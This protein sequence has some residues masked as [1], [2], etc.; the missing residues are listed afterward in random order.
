MKLFSK[1]SGIVISTMVFAVV[2]LDTLAQNVGIGTN[3][4][5][6]KLHVV[7]T[8][9]VSSLAGVGNRSVL[10]DPNGTLIIGTTANS[11]DWTILGNSGTNPATNFLG[12]LDNVDMTIRRNNIERVRVETNALNFQGALEPNNLPGQVGEV[13]QSNGPGVAPTWEMQNLNPTQIVSWGKFYINNLTINNNTNYI[14]TIG[15]ANCTP[16]STLTHTWVGPLPGG[17]AYGLLVT[18]VEAQNGQW[19]FHIRNTTGWNF[20][21]MSLSFV[22]WYGP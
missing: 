8:G 11:P 18:N 4:P 7:G 9:R 20:T 16:T 5:A 10:A 13:L 22:A 12:T 15:D 17:P 19:R 6:E 21:G 2:G 1:S 14:F 3:A